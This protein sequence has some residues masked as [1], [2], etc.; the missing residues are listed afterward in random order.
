MEN[1][2]QRFPLSWPHGWARTKFRGDSR[3]RVTLSESF[4]RLERE[5][6]RLR[7]VNPFLSSNLVL[8]VRGQPLANQAQPADTGVAVYFKLR[9]KGA[10]HDRVLA[11]DRYRKVEENIAAIAA[12]I[13]AL[14]AIERHGVGTIEQAFAGYTALPPPS[15]DNRAPWR[16]VFHLKPDAP[17]TAADVNVIYRAAAKRAATDE[18]R[19]LEL[20]LARDAAMQELGG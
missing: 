9:S 5:L 17:V 13:D 7:A 8:G 4:D 20:N 10:L 11:C 14:R 12:H 18:S 2:P 3:F 15:E 16:S 1:E 19:L 6:E